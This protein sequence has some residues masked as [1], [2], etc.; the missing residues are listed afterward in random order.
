M[1]LILAGSISLDSA[2]N[3]G[4]SVCWTFVKFLIFLDLQYLF[5]PHLSPTPP[6]P[7]PTKKWRENT[8]VWK[9]EKFLHCQNFKYLFIYNFID[10]ISFL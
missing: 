2:F 9:D 8:E 1:S 10:A 3:D 7:P 4:N 6:P 5:F